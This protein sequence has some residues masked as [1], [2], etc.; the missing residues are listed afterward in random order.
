MPR[1]VWP[2]LGLPVS[3][4]A[5]ASY[6]SPY[7]KSSV[8]FSG[9]EKGITD[10]LAAYDK[11]REDRDALRSVD[12]ETN[13][14]TSVL[15]RANSMD[16]RS[17]T[18]GQDLREYAQTAMDEALETSE[19]ETDEA[20]QAFR[21]RSL[22]FT[23]N[24][25]LDG[26]ERRRA[27][28]EKEGLGKFEELANGA[29]NSMR[30]DPEN[31][32]AYRDQLLGQVSRLKNVIAPD[33]FD[34]AVRQVNKN[35]PL[36]VAEGLAEA[37]NPEMALEYLDSDQAKDADP[38][39]IRSMKRTI[40]KIRSAN[41]AEHAR[42]TAWRRAD[43]TD[44]VNSGAINDPAELDR[45]Q[46]EEGLWT[47]QNAQSLV[48]LKQRIRAKNTSDTSTNRKLTS[49]LGDWKSGFGSRTQ[50]DADLGFDFLIQQQG[51]EPVDE[52]KLMQLGLY[53]TKVS[54]FVPSQ[55]QA[56]VRTGERSTDPAQLA[57]SAQISSVLQDAV[58][59][60]KTS[61]GKR[62]SQVE[63]L[64]RSAGM[65]YQTAAEL[66]IENEPDGL[67][68]DRRREDY[69]QHIKDAEFDPR[70]YLAEK[71]ELEPEQI[72]DRTVLNFNALQ[73]TMFTQSGD[74]AT[75]TEA[76]AVHL[77]QQGSMVSRIGGGTKYRTHAPEG[78][79]MRNSETARVLGPEAA[80]KIID[81]DVN[82][83]L[84]QL[85]LKSREDG[86]RYDLD[87]HPMDAAAAAAGKPFRYVVKHYDE[88]GFPAYLYTKGKDG[89][90][91]YMVYSVPTEQ[92]M[93]ESQYLSDVLKEQ[94]AKHTRRR[95]NRNVFHDDF[96]A[97]VEEWKQSLEPKQPPQTDLQRSIT[98]AG[99]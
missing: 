54:N 43:I 20:K 39:S 3:G 83:T 92:Q 93:Q 22:V 51:D 24:A 5:P 18:F 55:I 77:E 32:P 14:Q 7:A 66:V 62:I 88:N 47:E 9:V 25:L 33:K 13:F 67:M 38:A 19:F 70:V 8:D 86:R 69:P 85:G 56:R 34:S 81:M 53:A 98:E 90:R 10:V 50:G 41:E 79:L 74:L 64:H 95:K 78:V 84:D 28:L 96:D 36:V 45:I 11:G 27:I 21:Q 60:V 48:A 80:S 97:Q 71:F 73:K 59:G 58:P 1:R 4:N 87:V 44:Q 99:R 17:P 75:A 82:A 2:D 12:L 89:T 26:V 16:A 57:Q 49:V 42:E 31:A 23:K 46:K 37:G 94:E 72:D 40:A 61:A 6:E 63:A 29:L 76:A 30:E 52:A 91:Q 68:A 35:L 15:E 65:D